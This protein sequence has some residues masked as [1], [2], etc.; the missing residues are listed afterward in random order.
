VGVRPLLKVKNVFW[1]KT[2]NAV[3]LIFVLCV[4]DFSKIGQYGKNHANRQ[5]ASLTIPDLQS[6]FLEYGS[7]HPPGC[8]RWALKG[9]A[10]RN[11]K[12]S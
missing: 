2:H 11:E 6:R 8:V 4:F 5:N 7:T 10:L 1:K 3:T 12:Y 9:F